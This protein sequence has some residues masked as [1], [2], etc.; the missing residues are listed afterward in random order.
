M[1]SALKFLSLY[2]IRYRFE[3]QHNRYSI[4][5]IDSYARGRKY[6]R[7]FKTAKHMDD[8]TR[9]GG[10]YKY[11]EFINVVSFHINY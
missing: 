10:R 9:G 8:A 11:G 4:R 6:L 5:L 7:S 1:P 2:L 3:F